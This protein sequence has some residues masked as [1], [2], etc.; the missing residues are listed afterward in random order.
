MSSLARRPAPCRQGGNA[1]RFRLLLAPKLLEPCECEPRLAGKE[2]RRVS[3]RP[4][5]ARKETLPRRGN[6]CLAGKAQPKPRG[7][8][9][10]PAR[11]ARREKASGPSRQG[12]EPSATARGACGEGSEPSATTDGA[13]WGGW[14]ALGRRGSL[15]GEADRG[16]SRSGSDLGIMRQPY[17]TSSPVVPFKETRSRLR[18]PRSLLRASGPVGD[19]HLQKAG[20]KRKSGVPDEW[21]R[22]YA[23]P[24]P[25]VTPS[26]E[27]SAPVTRCERCG[28]AC[29]EAGTVGAKTA[30]T[31]GPGGGARDL[32]GRPRASSVSE[33]RAP[34]GRSC[35][36]PSVHLFRVNVRAGLGSSVRRDRGRKRVSLP[37]MRWMRTSARRAALRCRRWRGLAPR[38]PQACG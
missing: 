27:G 6:E 31:E 38:R 5:L 19:R 21:E 36:R 3:C 24:V 15:A 28:T 30:G 26:L 16:L 11:S 22:W 18:R 37:V 7:S 10:Y 32:H 14:V 9:V 4:R 34:R 1:I 2:K 17:V 8:K 33:M 35:W 13:C 25:D 23:S 12:S 29:G 20:L